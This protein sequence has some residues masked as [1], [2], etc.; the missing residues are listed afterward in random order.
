MGMKIRT[1]DAARLIKRLGRLSPTTMSTVL[2]KLQEMF[3]P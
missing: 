2:A 3:A 1:L